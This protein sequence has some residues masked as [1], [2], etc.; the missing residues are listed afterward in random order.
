MYT[1]SRLPHKTPT[2]R[3]YFVDQVSTNL[4]NFSSLSRFYLLM[5]IQPHSPRSIT[6]SG[7]TS[8]HFWYLFIRVLPNRPLICL[9]D[10][11]LL[12]RENSTKTLYQ[13]VQVLL[14]RL[15]LN[16]FGQVHA[17]L[18]KVVLLLQ[19]LNLRPGPVSSFIT[20]IIGHI[21][22]YRPTS[23]MLS[24]LDFIFLKFQ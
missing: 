11:I 5:Q 3:I 2:S 7:N 8:S 9:I 22:P 21:L 23:T 1:S 10:Q 18:P 24:R 16:L 6:Q 15:N 14:F 13:N 20:H 4:L 19:A 12:P 17:S